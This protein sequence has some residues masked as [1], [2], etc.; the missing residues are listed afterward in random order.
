M[1]YNKSALYQRIPGFKQNPS[2]CKIWLVDGLY[3]KPRNRQPI[4]KHTTV[5][6]TGRRNA[7]VA[8]AG[9][10]QVRPLFCAEAGMLKP[11]AQQLA[12]G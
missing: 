6:T 7:I 11:E 4:Y 8:N 9:G 3:R 2:L 10:V 12:A 5:G 1:C